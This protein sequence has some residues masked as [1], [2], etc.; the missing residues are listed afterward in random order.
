MFVFVLPA[1]FCGSVVGSLVKEG[2]K[3]LMLPWMVLY[4]QNRDWDELSSGTV[5]C[6]KDAFP[7][8][9]HSKIVLLDPIIGYRRR[10]PEKPY[11]PYK[12]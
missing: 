3:V 5:G 1:W 9:T 7:N 8:T 4:S 10:Q 12:P 6:Q 2:V 11:K